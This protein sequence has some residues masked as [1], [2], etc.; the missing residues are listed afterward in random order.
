MSTNANLNYFLLKL[1]IHQYELTRACI[2]EETP[3]LFT[4]TISG[5]Q[6]FWVILNAPWPSK[7]FTPVFSL[8]HDGMSLKL[9]N[10]SLHIYCI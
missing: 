2:V 3:S 8:F 6:L 4:N 5:H 10:M 1:A 9:Q 7:V